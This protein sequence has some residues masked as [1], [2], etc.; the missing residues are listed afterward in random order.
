[1]YK[2][3]SSGR[4]VLNDKPAQIDNKFLEQFPPFLEFIK[5]APQNNNEKQCEK[6]YLLC[7]FVKIHLFMLTLN[8]FSF[9]GHEFD[10]CF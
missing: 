5:N 1:V 6:I 8:P 10:K 7:C 3:T 9:A 4:K 2:I